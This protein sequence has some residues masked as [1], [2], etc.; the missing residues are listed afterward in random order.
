[1]ESGSS[2]KLDTNEGIHRFMQEVD[3]QNEKYLKEIPLDEMM[4]EQQRLLQSLDPA[5]VAYLRTRSKQSM[6]IKHATI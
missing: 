5:V 2:N 3:K 1:M 4:L 6:L